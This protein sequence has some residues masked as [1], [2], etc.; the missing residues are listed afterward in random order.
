MGQMDGM[1]AIVT[2][3]GDGIGRGIARRYAREGATVVVAELNAEAGQ[4]VADELAELG[5]P[6][7]FLQTD[8]SKKD[9]VLRMVSTTLE[10]YGRIDVLVNNAIT[11]T[12][13][14]PLHMKTDE[15]LAL[16]LGVGLWSVWWAMQAVLEPMKAQGGGRI[17]NFYSV[18]ADNG[19]W[20]HG[21]Y[22]AVKAG[23]GALTRTAGIQ[24]APHGILVNAISPIAA[25]AAFQKMVEVNPGILQAIP[26]MIPI[27]RMGDPEEDIAPVAVFLAG[28]GSRYITGATIPVDGGLHV[29]RLNTRPPDLSVFEG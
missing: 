7:L 12:P 13:E 3:G 10:R 24:W 11:V 25:S 14:V 18:D 28:E 2:G 17:I 19:N 4:R 20:L 29:P 1:V 8:V 26:M 27:G 9:D 6:G 23:V 16:T 21:D 15:M 5:A 22:N